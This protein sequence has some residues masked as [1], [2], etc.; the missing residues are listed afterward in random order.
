MPHFSIPYHTSF[1][2]SP[3]ILFTLT[4]HVAIIK[5]FVAVS[6]PSIVVGVVLDTCYATI[7]TCYC[8]TGVFLCSADSCPCVCA[9]LGH[10]TDMSML[11]TFVCLGTK[12]AEGAAQG[13]VLGAFLPANS[14]WRSDAVCR[15]ERLWR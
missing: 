15:A 1:V 12:Q 13:A 7:R 8:T 11:S 14:G 6:A 4:L 3:T 10:D 9:C 2:Y 5:A